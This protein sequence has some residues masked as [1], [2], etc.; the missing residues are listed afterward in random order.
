ME[1]NATRAERRNAARAAGNI[2]KWRE[3]DRHAI[4]H[5]I[6]NAKGDKEKRITAVVGPPK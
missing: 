5:V 4:T 3:R 6:I 2:G 1:G